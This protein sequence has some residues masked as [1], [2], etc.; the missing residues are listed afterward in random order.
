MILMS[1]CLGDLSAL[2]AA[3]MAISAYWATT[4]SKYTYPSQVI[5]DE[6]IKQ[7][8]GYLLG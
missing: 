8:N 5:W 2:P 1:W 7:H 4:S 3:C 6:H